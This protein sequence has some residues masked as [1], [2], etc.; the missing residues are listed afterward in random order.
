MT[1][2]PNHRYLKYVDLEGNE[3][4]QLKFVDFPLLIFIHFEFQ[5]LH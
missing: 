1:G 5:T 3:I 4:V 2:K